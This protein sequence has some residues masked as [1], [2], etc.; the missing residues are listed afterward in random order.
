MPKALG[1][2]LGYR[3][4]TNTQYTG[5]VLVKLLIEDPGE[6]GK[7]VAGKA[8]YRDSKGNIYKGRVVGL[9][10]RRGV[11]LVRFKPNLPGQAIGGLVEITK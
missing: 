8:L 11:V 3:R 10:G 4:G 9:H 7:Y 1:I 2:V 6:A 5:Q